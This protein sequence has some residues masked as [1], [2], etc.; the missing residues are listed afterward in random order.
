VRSEQVIDD[1][2]VMS[3]AHHGSRRHHLPSPAPPLDLPAP[4]SITLDTAALV[5]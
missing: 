1:R 3:G 5:G 2:I 4:W